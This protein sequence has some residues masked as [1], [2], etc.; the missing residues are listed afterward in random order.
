MSEISGRRESACRYESS[1]APGSSTATTAGRSRRIARRTSMANSM[2]PGATGKYVKLPRFRL[3]ESAD[4]DIPQR[5][6]SQCL[7]HRGAQH[8]PQIVL[9]RAGANQL[10]GEARDV[11]AV[12]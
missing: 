11:D 2:R 10:G 9:N 5:F 6:F 7:N 4:R 1:S 8:E 3:A 12:A